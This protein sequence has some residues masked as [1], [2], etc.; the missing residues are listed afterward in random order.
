FWAPII[1][2]LLIAAASVE[3][4]SWRQRPGAYRGKRYDR[5]GTAFAGVPMPPRLRGPAYGSQ[6]RNTLGVQ[7]E[8][9]LWSTLAT[10]AGP[11][12]VSVRNI[13]SLTDDRGLMRPVAN[14]AGPMGPFDLYLQVLGNEFD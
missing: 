13:R 11:L 12:T 8:S 2:V 4:F 7:P 10:Q 3:L 1:I 14:E 9:R 5:G 6:Q